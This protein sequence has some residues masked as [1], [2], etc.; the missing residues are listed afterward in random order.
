MADHQINAFEDTPTN[1]EPLHCP[2]CGEKLHDGTYKEAFVVCQEA[3]GP[4]GEGDVFFLDNYK[5]TK[6]PPAW[7]REMKDK[8][9][10][11]GCLLLL[12]IVLAGAMLIAL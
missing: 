8:Q 2:F 7:F 9:S 11:K 3:D 6:E 5:I 4:D 12:L 10:K 1:S